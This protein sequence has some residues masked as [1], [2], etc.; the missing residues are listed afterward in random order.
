MNTLK[1]LAVVAVFVGLGALL[2]KQ[3]KLENDEAPSIV[4][5][6]HAQTTPIPIKISSLVP[7]TNAQP[8]ALVLLTIPGVTNYVI[9]IAN[10]Q[11]QIGG[12][13]TNF[14]V[15]TASDLS[16]LIYQIGANGTNFTY[17]IGANDTNYANSIFTSISNLIV[18]IT[19]TIFS[20]TNTSPFTNNGMFIYQTGLVP[21]NNAPFLIRVSDG[22]HFFGKDAW[23]DP[24]DYWHNPNIYAFQA[25]NFFDSNSVTSIGGEMQSRDWVNGTCLAINRIGTYSDGL[26]AFSSHLIFGTQGGNT[27]QWYVNAHPNFGSIWTYTSNSSVWFSVSNGNLAIINKVG[28]Q[29]PGTNK[30]GVLT[31][32][33]TG[34]LDWLATPSGSDVTNYANSVSNS[35]YILLSN[36]DDTILQSSTNYTDKA[37]SNRVTVAASTGIGVATNNS[38]NVMIYTISTAP[39]VVLSGTN[40]YVTVTATNGTNF[41]VVNSTGGGGSVTNFGAIVTNVPYATNFIMDMSFIGNDYY[42]TNMMNNHINV[43]PTNFFNGLN[44]TMS[45]TGTN[46]YTNWNVYFTWPPSATVVWLSITNGSPTTT[47]TSNKMQFYSFKCRVSST[48]TQVVAAFKEQP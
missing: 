44:W 15:I 7:V 42:M 34:N 46:I 5:T 41:Y 39:S 31:D 33:G 30:A 45:L 21:S 32:D 29:W 28:Y 48:V 4:A 14:A 26:S 25:I 9:T 17:Q 12:A 1:K 16:N 35:I 47:I 40:T 6:A 24:A 2:Q 3:L 20:Y 11:M 13:T 18:A 19:N 37:A 36:R 22:S 10:L 23:A 38:G 43:L 8:N 27:D